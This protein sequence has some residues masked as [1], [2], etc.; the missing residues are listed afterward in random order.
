MNLASIASFF[1]ATHLARGTGSSGR[2]G[3]GGSRLEQ[4]APRPA[5]LAG[6]AHRTGY[7]SLAASLVPGGSGLSGAPAAATPAPPEQSRGCLE[8]DRGEG[9]PRGARQG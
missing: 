4:A 6:K 8:G 2:L 7:P 5:A 1:P 3:T 9:D